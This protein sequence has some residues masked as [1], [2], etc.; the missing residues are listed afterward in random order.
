MSIPAANDRAA[1][2]ICCSK[3]K[4]AVILIS[5]KLW[6]KATPLRISSE[7]S[8]S[9]KLY[10]VEVCVSKFLRTEKRNINTYARTSTAGAHI[11]GNMGWILEFTHRHLSLVRVQ[12]VNLLEHV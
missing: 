9:S 6:K 5:Q 4:S 7:K 11:K 1:M 10:R 12:R 3:F 2:M 8:F